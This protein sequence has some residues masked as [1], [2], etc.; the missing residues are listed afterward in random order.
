MYGGSSYCTLFQTVKYQYLWIKRSLEFRHLL[1]LLSPVLKLLS[2]SSSL[3]AKRQNSPFFF[4]L[5]ILLIYLFDRERER[6]NTSKGEQQLE[7]EGEAG[8]PT[9]QRA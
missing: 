4:F 2:L 5:K 8:L 3:R 9:E 1:Y 7:G 6:E